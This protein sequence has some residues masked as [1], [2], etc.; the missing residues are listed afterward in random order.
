MSE[1]EL[2]ESPIFQVDSCLGDDLDFVNQQSC[3]H[4]NCQWY[5]E[6]INEDTGETSNIEFEKCL[7][8]GEIFYDE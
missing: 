8:C 6:I 4:F 3:Q 5:N 1:R 2:S 7:D